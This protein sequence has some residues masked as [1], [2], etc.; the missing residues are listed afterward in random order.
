MNAIIY[1][2]KRLECELCQ[3]PL[4]K[5]YFLD[6]KMH[7]LVDIHRPH[8]PYILL[9]NVMREKKT[10]KSMILLQVFSESDVLK[11]VNKIQL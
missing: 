7:D 10:S 5:K 3:T 2:W 6:G 8:T 9:E 1:Y 4:P 11:L